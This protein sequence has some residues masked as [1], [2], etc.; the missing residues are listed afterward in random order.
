MR[1]GVGSDVAPG[2][3]FLHPMRLP[4]WRGWI[5]G[6]GWQALLQGGLP[7]HVRPQVQ[8]LFD[9]H[10]RGLHLGS[11]RPVA[12]QLFR[13]QG[14]FFIID[15]TYVVPWKVSYFLLD[16][17]ISNVCPF[18]CCC[19]WHS[20]IS[21]DWEG[22]SRFAQRRIFLHG[23]LASSLRQVYGRRFRRRRRRWQ[24][25]K[26]PPWPQNKTKQTKTNQNVFKNCQGRRKTQ[27]RKQ[28]TALLISLLLS[29][30]FL[31]LCCSSWSSFGHS[32]QKKQ[33]RVFILQNKKP[34]KQ[35]MMM[36]F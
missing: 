6:E 12:S 9:G 27:T 30:T 23:R 31:S 18:R 22:L 5:P 3:L 13:L 32:H 28:H 36:M 2:S 16:N 7:G 14:K 10:H 24:P 21:L 15:V 29:H 4:V 20:Y 35:K 19:C 1:D 34:D 17:P 33:S 8:R 25:M 11:Q 26:W